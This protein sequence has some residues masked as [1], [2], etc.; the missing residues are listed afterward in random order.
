MPSAVVG[1]TAEFRKTKANNWTSI[2]SAAPTNADIDASAAEADA[3]I[4]SAAAE[5]KAAQAEDDEAPAIV[6]DNEG[7]GNM[8]SGAF[9]GLQTAEQVS[10]AVEKKRAR[11]RRKAE[12]AND[13]G[14]GGETIYRDASG[15]IINVAMKRAEARKKAEEEERRKRQEEEAARGDVQRLQKEKRRQEL[16]DA[17]Y[18]PFARH[19]DDVE[20]NEEMKEQDRWNDPAAGFIEKK[21]EGKSATGRPL[22]KG[23]AAPNRYGIRPGHR[24][25]GVDR[26][27]G[28]EKKWFA[29]RNRQ[30]DKR[31]M[32]YAWQMD[33]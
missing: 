14:A 1:R 21:R 12:E 29:A 4:S 33:E 19:V 3:I 18:K 24:W 2:G 25:D 28:F 15:R 10:A 11:D 5:R 27:N 13:G 31:N 9:A 17:K 26:S 30:A 7:I 16:E 20:M 6:D 23:V 22:Y 32:E 8:A